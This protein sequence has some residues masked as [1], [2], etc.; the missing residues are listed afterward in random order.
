MDYFL[1]N[2]GN[3]FRQ[4]FRLR[5]PA[6][7]FLENLQFQLS[8]APRKATIKDVTLHYDGPKDE[9]LLKWLSIPSADFRLRQDRLYPHRSNGEKTDTRKLPKNTKTTDVTHGGKSYRC[10]ILGEILQI[11]YQGMNRQRIEKNNFCK[12][13]IQTCC[14]FSQG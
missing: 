9:S 13:I 3:E 7:G 8:E 10:V 6:N 12:N 14:V 1:I 11:Y 4:W 5:Q 2:K